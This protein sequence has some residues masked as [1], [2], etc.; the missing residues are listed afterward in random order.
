[1]LV[2]YAPGAPLFW[3]TPELGIFLRG[4]HMPMAGSEEPSP[5]PESALFY[6]QDAW[7]QDLL[8]RR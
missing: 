6:A 1:M 7:C 3:R 2:K 8:V 5:A 4:E